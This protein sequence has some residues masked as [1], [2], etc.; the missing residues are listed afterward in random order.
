MSCWVVMDVDRDEIKAAYSM[1]EV[2]ERYGFQ[3][4]RAGFISC[5]FHQGDRTP[6]MK[7]YEKDFHCHA[8]GAHGDIF[9]FMMQM[10]GISFKEAFHTLS[11][12]YQPGSRKALLAR[13]ERFLMEKKGREAAEKRFR[14]WHSAR[15]DEVCRL[16]RRL[17][18][19]V[20]M[21][22]PLTEEW[23]AAVN[24]REG[25]RYKYEV[26][27]YG[28]RQEQEEMRERDE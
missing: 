25:T 1:R 3:P 6:S 21:L 13:R 7:L 26:L 8:C 14:N 15:L 2:A 18:R 28:T 24:M 27:I 9:D 17:D 16:L 23:A 20:P 4:N 10:D 22:P 12:D 5:P 19:V 11:G